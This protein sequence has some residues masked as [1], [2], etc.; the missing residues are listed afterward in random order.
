MKT[1]LLVIDAPASIFSRSRHTEFEA[2]HIQ[3]SRAPAFGDRFS[4]TSGMV[5]DGDPLP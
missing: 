2:A 4:Q 5:T 3:R 1:C